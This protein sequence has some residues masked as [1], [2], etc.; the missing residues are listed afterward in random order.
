M[1]PDTQSGVKTWQWVVT[2]IVVIVLIVIGVMVFSNKPSKAPATSNPD[3]VNTLS[4]E[5]GANGIVMSDQYPGNV[6]YLSSVQ[7]A[8]GGWVAIHKDSNGQPGAIIGSAWAA[9][10]ISPVK[11]TLTE[12]M[13]DG[14]TY[15]A[16]LHSDNGD[17]KFNASDDLPLKDA[18]DNIIMRV[19]HSSFSAGA[20]IKG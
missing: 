19:F 6:V 1:N 20:N 7:L 13:I 2:A 17:Q 4:N 11:V 16:M 12:P 14:G 3:L 18:K 9:A 15:Y 10:G 5:P 8:K